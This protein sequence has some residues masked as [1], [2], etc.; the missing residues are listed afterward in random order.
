MNSS[1]LSPTVAAQ[2]PLYRDG[3]LL[4]ATIQKYVET[5]LRIFYTE[6]SILEDEDIQK[7]YE[8]FGPN[9]FLPKSLE[10]EAFNF[11]NLVDLVT[12]SIW[13][14]T[15]G[16]EFL[17]A[18]VEYLTPGGGTAGKV[19]RGKARADA[20]TYTLILAMMTATGTIEPPLMDD[21]SHIF[22]VKAWEEKEKGKT[23]TKKQEV[24]N[25][26]R[27]FQID[28]AAASD[29]IE[30]ENIRRTQRG[31]KSFVAFDPRILETSV[32]I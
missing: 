31:E 28:L 19:K 18:V 9:K 21:W 27:Q 20:M 12:E 2:L 10:L 23:T 22:E 32:S 26:I 1:G 11:A 29:D 15:G 8:Y 6:E 14:V 7:F 24:L 25:V 5:Y 3:M 17:G 30:S 13:Y 4:W 16:H